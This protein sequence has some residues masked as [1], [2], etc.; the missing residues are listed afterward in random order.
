[1]LGWASQTGQG[2]ANFLVSVLVNSVDV[3]RD[4]RLKA[5]KF[6][7]ILGRRT[8]IHCVL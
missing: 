1:M 5:R 4:V 2:I 7:G 6:I 8:S 3:L